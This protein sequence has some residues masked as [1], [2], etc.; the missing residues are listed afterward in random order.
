LPQETIVFN[1]VKGRLNLTVEVDPKGRFLGWDIT[2]LGAGASEYFGELS[3]DLKIFRAGS[4]IYRERRLLNWPSAVPWR[5]SPLGWAGQSV[6]ASLWALGSADENEAAFLE[7]VAREFQKD[8][9]FDGRLG[10]TVRGGLLLARH[11][12][13][14]VE[15]A[16]AIL[17]KVWR[18]VREIW[19]GVPYRPRIWST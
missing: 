4:L 2:S 7:E 13:P 15:K 16:K 9:P 3:Q 12:G 5:R 19:G 11:L 8:G 6:A 10:I 17:E 18:S 1:G 14:S